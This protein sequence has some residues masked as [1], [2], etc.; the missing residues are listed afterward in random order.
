MVVTRQCNNGHIINPEKVRVLDV[1]TNTSKRLLSEMIN[2]NLQESPINL[3]DD[4]GE[5]N[6]SYLSVMYDLR[7]YKQQIFI[8]IS[9]SLINKNLSYHVVFILYT[10]FI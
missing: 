9:I 10:C 7:N 5:L 8:M 3:K 2:I 1:E 6:D 4:T